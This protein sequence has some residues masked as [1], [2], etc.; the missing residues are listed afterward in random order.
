MEFIVLCKIGSY[1]RR[2]TDDGDDD[3][4]D[5]MGDSPD[6]NKRWISASSRNSGVGERTANSV[7]CAY[8]NLVY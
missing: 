4:D 3:D 5:V 6:C 2:C 8:S 1:G 7:I